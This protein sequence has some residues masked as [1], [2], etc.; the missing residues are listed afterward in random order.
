MSATDKIKNR[1]HDISTRAQAVRAVC[2]E[3]Q[4]DENG[5]YID[6]ADARQDAIFE[7]ASADPLLSTLGDKAVDV[8]ASWASSIAAHV[9]TF[10]EDIRDEVLASAH[11]TLENLLTSGGNASAT[12]TAMLES[13][14]AGTGATT[15]T[16]DGVMLREHFAGLILPVSLRATTGDAATH[17]PSNKDETELFEMVRVAANS[18]GD[19]AAD[20]VLTP[21]TISQFSSMKQRYAM[22][23]ADNVKFTFKTETGV[24]PE[25]KAKPTVGKRNRF[26]HNGRLAA[27]DSIQGIPQLTVYGATVFES[28]SASAMNNA[29]G[30]FEVS[31]LAE[32]ETAKVD[33]QL[34]INIEA[35]PELTPVISHKMLAYTIYPSQS[36]IAAEAT[37]QAFWSMQ[38]EYGMDLTS[39]Q[40]SAMREFLAYEKD[41]RNLQAMFDATIFEST[42][43]VKLSAALHYKETYELLRKHLI[44]VSTR[45]VNRTE[46]A[47]LTGIFAGLNASAIIKSMGS[48][49]FE[50][51]EGYTQEPNVHYI[52]RLFGQFKVFEAPVIIPADYLLCYARGNEH[53]RAGFVTGDAIPAIMFRHPTTPTLTDRN[54]LWSLDYNDVHPNGGENWFELVKFD[55][56]LDAHSVVIDAEK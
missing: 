26:Y 5:A 54:T 52:G 40:M 39:M 42:F 43:G 20:T 22:T 7:A 24:L 21:K 1:L 53:G 14:N 36:I 41:K 35:A 44:G 13:A 27:H 47:G 8:A 12:A 31:L 37:I 49:M 45:M 3:T 18:F 19:T 15:N 48:P 11:K 4:F 51:V 30:E 29:T 50:Q 28:I 9:N 23:S 6:C 33:I 56:S 34:E 17:I 25:A 55:S 2:I 10:G 32:D 16:S 38:R 46:V